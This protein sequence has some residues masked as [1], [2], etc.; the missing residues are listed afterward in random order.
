VPVGKVWQIAGKF[1]QGGVILQE[2]N[3]PHPMTTVS[4]EVRKTGRKWSI[5]AG[6]SILTSYPTEQIAR[7]ALVSNAK[8]WAYWA[9]SAGVSIANSTPKVVRA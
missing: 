1:W 5:C 3:A 2:S 4:L 8:F 6:K 7:E 9:Q